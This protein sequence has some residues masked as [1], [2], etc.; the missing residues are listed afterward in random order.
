MS[1][2]FVL[3]ERVILKTKKKSE[4]RDII[5]EGNKLALS[6]PRRLRWPR[7]PPSALE[8]YRIKYNKD[9]ET[10]REKKAFLNS[11][12]FFSFFFFRER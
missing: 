7:Q 8:Y 2:G 1:F 3:F 9:K 5:C 12:Y 4:G 11:E 6:I 10:R